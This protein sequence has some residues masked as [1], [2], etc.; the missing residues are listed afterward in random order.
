MIT[1]ALDHIFRRLFTGRLGAEAAAELRTAHHDRR[2]NVGTVPALLW[3]AGHL[4][5]PSTY[6]LALAL[7]RQRRSREEDRVARA[8]RGGRLV[9]LL[10]VKLGMRTLVK[11]P[12]VSAVSGLA[13]AVTVA[14]AIGSFTFARDFLL[15]PPLPLPDGDRI[16]SLG[17]RT[18][19]RNRTER[20]L[21]HEFALWRE[22][23]ESVELV[24]MWRSS[25]AN[26]IGSDG[27]GDRVSVARMS[28]TGFQVAGVPPLLGR[29]PTAEDEVPGAPD[30]IVIG[31]EE[32]M[33][34]FDA[35]PDILGRRIVLDGVPHT[36]IAVM[37]E[38]FGFPYAE[39]LWV[40]LKDEPADYPLP[41]ATATPERAGP[42]YFAFARLVDGV[43]LEQARAEMESLMQARG[44]DMPETHANVRGQVMPYTDTHTGMD[45][46]GATEMMFVRIVLGLMTALVLIPFVNVAILTYARTAT[47]VG[48]IAVR[49]ALGAS[50]RRI[51]A[52]LTAEAMV[53]CGLGGAVGVAIAVW[54][55]A[56]VDLYL[57]TEWATALPFWS[58]SGTEPVAL[59]YALG[60]VV[61]AAVVSG[62]IPALK[63]T[64]ADVQ[65]SLNRGA[66][67]NG[68]RLGR[69]WTLL[70][71]VQVAT[72]V[73]VL[74]WA[75]AVAWEAEGM[76][77]TRTSF[78]AGSFIAARISG[79]EIS[80]SFAPLSGTAPTIE[81]VGLLVEA[82]SAYP[83]VRGVT[84]ATRLPGDLFATTWRVHIDGM[85]PPPNGFGYPVGTIFVA[86]DFLG[87]L[88]VAVQ[89]GRDFHPTDV[90]AEVRPVIVN[91]T[92]V[93][94]V[95]GD[96]NAI[97][98]RIR[99]V[100]EFGE[101][102]AP[103][104]E[105]V[106]VVDD[107]ARNPLQPRASK[108]RVF[109]LLNPTN[110]PGS[111]NV[112][113]SVPPPAIDFTGELRRTVAAVDPGL[114]VQRVT[115]LAALDDPFR[116]GAR[117]L[118][119][120]IVIVLLSI[121]LLASASVSAMMSLTVTRLRREI[122]IRS[123]LGAHPRRVLVRV[124]VG[125]ARQ[126][127]LGAGLGLLIGLSIPPISIDGG[128]LRADWRLLTA[129]AAVLVFAGLVAGWGPARRGLKI[130]PT[131]ALKEG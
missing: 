79:S 124:M 71:V 64:G 10:D 77:A 90:A 115:A 100:G 3:Y 103:W 98:R 75:G 46:T 83:T 34:R 35:R 105:I 43:S 129:V 121:T 6:Q 70:V 65:T 78:D 20:R 111:V 123:A 48:E 60:L 117:T 49:S 5:R 107:L 122:G 82:L 18:T 15:R 69:V 96:A 97:G 130:Q 86:Q 45:D 110:P 66:S 109:A 87:T 57:E 37:P 9:S 38:G 51:V 104:R 4:F 56:K 44:R 27:I 23:M 68:L 76:S 74:P 99:D 72:A 119:R 101:N 33:R 59:L 19:D 85:P 53:L 81:R 93:R 42:G 112:I 113:V 92:F 94:S 61:L 14:V 89:S 63:A 126:L 118:A 41:I 32:W 127:A 11:H 131:E 13:I 17:L 55:R 50:R 8:R 52:Q 28:V 84:L 125:S 47:R 128:V 31:H 24:S 108:P 120:A 73:A 67:G 21:I 58:R 26:L 62:G 25:P 12:A 95:L 40:A 22:E 106:G 29:W 116:T 1:R 114:T 88:G 39:R 54:A 30:V 36:V 2:L 16:V 7:R 91:R 102:E 80:G